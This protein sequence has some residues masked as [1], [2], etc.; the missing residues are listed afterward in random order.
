MGQGGDWPMAGLLRALLEN[1]FDLHFEQLGY[2][3]GDRQRRIELSA[4]DRIDA[5]S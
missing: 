4:L 3:E 2:A 1:L 5:L